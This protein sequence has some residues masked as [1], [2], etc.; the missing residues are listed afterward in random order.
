MP[1]RELFAIFFLI[2]TPIMGIAIISIP[3]NIKL[4]SSYYKSLP[5]L[6]AKEKAGS[7]GCNY[8]ED[9]TQTFPKNCL[10]V[11]QKIIGSIYPEKLI[12]ENNAY[13]TTGI[14]ESSLAEQNL[15][16]FVF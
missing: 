15:K 2:H 11:N 3:E 9:K 4:S 8:N 13:R 7:K 6:A 14:N 5:V 1:L 10:A 16:H 12:F